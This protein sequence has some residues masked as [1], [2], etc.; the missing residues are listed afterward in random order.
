MLTQSPKG[1][2]CWAPIGPAMPNTIS[3][4][5]TPSATAAGR[6]KSFCQR[7]PRDPN[8][9][10]IPFAALIAFLLQFFGSSSRNAASS[11]S[12]CTESTR[13]PSAITTRAQSAKNSLASASTR[14]AG[15]ASE[16]RVTLRSSAISTVAGFR[17]GALA[18]GVSGK[19]EGDA[20]VALAL[21]ADARH[22]ESA[23]LGGVLHV[24]A[25]AGLQVD[26]GDLEQPHASFA[27]RR[28][29]RHGLHQ[30]RLG[31]ELGVGDPGR[32]RW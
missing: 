11:E 10:R 28:R 6:P 26:A 19:G 32:P 21:G 13:P 12:L 25:A 8:S 22:R 2:N 7:S 31:V 1:T 17:S 27:A 23:D 20:L 3:P 16:S 9:P 18:N 29:H 15:S 4:A 5:C 14:S 30:L 24:R